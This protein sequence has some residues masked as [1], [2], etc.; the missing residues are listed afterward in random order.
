[1]VSGTKLTV[2]IEIVVRIKHPDSQF[3]QLLESIGDQASFLE[4]VEEKLDIRERGV[5]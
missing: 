1:M 3:A 2:I 5:R 4:P